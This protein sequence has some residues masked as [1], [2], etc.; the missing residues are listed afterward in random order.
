V[1]SRPVEVGSPYH[2][3]IR[4]IAL[5]EK[6]GLVVEILGTYPR[7]RWLLWRH[8]LPSAVKALR[9][10]GDRAT[11]PKLRATGTRL[12]HAVSRTLAIVPFD[13]RC[14]VRSLVLTR[15]LARRGIDSVLV[16]GVSVDPKFAAHAWVESGG[17]A[18]L[19]PMDGGSRL[20][21]I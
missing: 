1:S 6:L 16:I 20:L 7:A 11:D 2:E 8:D 10:E 15:M 18:L 17:R 9:G 3:L 12:G 14:L 4:P 19:Q 5:T 13:S 21:E